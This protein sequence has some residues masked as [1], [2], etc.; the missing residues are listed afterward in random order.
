MVAWMS[1][2]VEL[3]SS[4]RESDRNSD[5]PRHILQFLYNKF[6][7]LILNL[8]YS[9]EKVLV[10]LPTRVICCTSL[11]LILPILLLTGIIIRTC[12]PILSF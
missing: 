11:A 10:K 12:R 5:L 1:F 8:V 3:G 9:H 7:I 6:F 4:L 2:V